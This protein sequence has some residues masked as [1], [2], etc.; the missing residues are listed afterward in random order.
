MINMISSLPKYE[1]TSEVIKDLY[2]PIEE[3]IERLKGE[4]SDI[5]MQENIDEATWGIALQEEEL[6]LKANG[7]LDLETRRKIVKAKIKSQPP[8]SKKQMQQV[9]QSFVE[10]SQIK[11]CF[12]DFSFEILLKTTGGVFE[13]IPH[14]EKIVEEFKP[15][16][17]SFI[18][19]ICYLE[20]LNIKI[21]FLKLNTEKFKKSGT[22]DVSD[23]VRETTAGIKHN[24]YFRDQQKYFHTKQNRSSSQVSFLE[25]FGKKTKY[26]TK[27]DI[28]KNICQET[29]R[30][31]FNKKI[32]TG[33]EFFKNKYLYTLHSWKG[34]G[35]KKCSNEDL[36]AFFKQKIYKKIKKY[37][38]TKF[39]I[40]GSS[41]TKEAA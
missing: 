36:G 39:Q 37:E 4:L 1:R 5:R 21:N 17:L 3:E 14:I 32:Y 9:I 23:S 31:S 16:H 33:G 27:C 8:S 6:A 38:S 13:E 20:F 30:V 25:N 12:E 18:F 34:E 7:S 11:E 29:S 2:V 24:Y 10:D 19:N 28:S 35:I 22:L 41:S 26:K 40:C 15:A